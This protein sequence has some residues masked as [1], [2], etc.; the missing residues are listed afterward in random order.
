MTKNILIY[1]IGN[2]GDII[3]AIPAMVGLR[4]HYPDAWITL[5]T[6][7]EVEGSPDPENIL[8]GNEFLNEIIT[9][10]TKRIHKVRYLYHLYRKLRLLRRELLVYNSLSDVTYK[11]LLRDW[12]FFRL[13][14]FKVLL[15]FKK[16]RPNEVYVEGTVK[17]TSFPQEVERLLGLLS[18]LGVD[19]KTV[20]FRL[21]RKERDRV[22]V[23]KIWIEYNLKNCQRIVAISPSGKF[24]VNHWDVRN[25]VRVAFEL[26]KKFSAR[27]VLIGGA[28]EKLAGDTIVEGGGDGIIN[29]IGKINYMES[30]EVLSRCDLLVSNDCGPAHLAAAVGKPVVGIYSSRNY[31]GAWHPWGCLHTV[32]RNDNVPC[33]FCFKTECETKECINSITVDQVLEACGKYLERSGNEGVGD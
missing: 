23:D 18:P 12:F 22:T 26:Q 15:G 4:R 21:P 20:E 24:S 32:L 19:S 25:Y 14:G 31:P 13:V 16:T 8:E 33:R 28:G 5:L 11:R 2:L 7:K 30:A 6:N 3:C 17:C 9:Y 10:E 27:I 1:R 29:L